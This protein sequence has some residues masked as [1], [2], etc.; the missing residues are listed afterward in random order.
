MRFI[1]VCLVSLGATGCI[2][3]S[4]TAGERLQEAVNEMNDAARWGRFDIAGDRVHPRYRG[5]FAST[6]AKWGG[7]FQIADMEIV[8]VRLQGGE[9]TAT[10]T[11]AYGW[12]SY[13]TMTLHRTIVRQKWAREDG[14]FS[15]TEESVVGGD[16]L[17]LEPPP[18][19]EEP[20]EPAEGV[21]SVEPAT[22]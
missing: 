19:P 18:E 17:L 10:S 6:H 9:D 12:Y 2:F 5:K 11:V 1:L 15:L 8:D 21:G 13:E 7:A 16:A 20:E 4:M 22:M 3:Q 14:V